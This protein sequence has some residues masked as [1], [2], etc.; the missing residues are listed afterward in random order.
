[1]LGHKA[2]L[3]KFNKNESI[4]TFFNDQNDMRLQK[5]KK[6]KKTYKKH[7]EMETK[8]YTPK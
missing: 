3:S 6:K 5:K 4:S 8:Q 2:G 7:K 1:M